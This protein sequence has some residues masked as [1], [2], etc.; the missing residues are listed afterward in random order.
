MMHDILHIIGLCP[1]AMM[2]PDIIDFIIYQNI[3]LKWLRNIILSILR[4]MRSLL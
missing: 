1:D 3:D 4:R 2:H